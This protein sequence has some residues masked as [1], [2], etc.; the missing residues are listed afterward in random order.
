M[1]DP[2]TKHSKS[3]QG[4]TI[5]LYEGE[6][7]RL[8]VPQ[9]CLGAKSKIVLVLGFNEIEVISLCHRYSFFVKHVY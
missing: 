4:H 9:V 2:A 6:G 3:S 8:R 1:P 7:D 5:K